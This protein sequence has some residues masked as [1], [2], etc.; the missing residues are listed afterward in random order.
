MAYFLCPSTTRAGV[1]LWTV[2]SLRS[3][4][5]H[6]P[7][8][9]HCCLCLGVTVTLISVGNCCRVSGRDLYDLSDGRHESHMYVKLEEQSSTLSTSALEMSKMQR[10][11]SLHPMT[12]WDNR[13]YV[14]TT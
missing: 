1:D 11:S 8:P 6:Q 10:M 12:N 3:Q 7:D 4:V 13:R 2:G 9:V 5:P 14:R